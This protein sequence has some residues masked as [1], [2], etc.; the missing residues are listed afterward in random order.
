MKE[1]YSSPTEANWSKKGVAAEKNWE[2]VTAI[3]EGDGDVLAKPEEK[4]CIWES[5][6]EE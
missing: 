6:N 1:L 2:V 4:P 3:Q 5:P